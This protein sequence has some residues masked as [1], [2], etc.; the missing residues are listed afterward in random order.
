MLIFS[1]LLSLVQAETIDRIAA[2]VNSDIV[3]LSEVY[4]AGLDFIPTAPNRRDAELEVLDSLIL[5]K[6]VEQELNKLA[7]AVTEEELSKALKDVAKS[8]NLEPDQLRKE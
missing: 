1:F 3:L 7:M 5:E 8:N 4:E 2:V 6:L